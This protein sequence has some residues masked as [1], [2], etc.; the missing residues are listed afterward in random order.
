MESEFYIIPKNKAKAIFEEAISLAKCV[1]VDQLDC[2]VSCARQNTDKT[3][4]EVLQL[5][6]KD[7]R[8]F[9]NFVIR[10]PQDNFPARTDIGLSTGGPI[11]YFLWI[12]INIDKAREM[13]NKYKL[14]QI[15]CGGD[16]WHPI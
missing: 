9:Y 14:K 1:R 5:G 13:I 16:V 6:L 10:A 12:D 11:S 8:T 7:K 2:S 15:G 3:I 4:Q